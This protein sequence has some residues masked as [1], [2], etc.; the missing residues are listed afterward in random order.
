MTSTNILR[1]LANFYNSLPD[2]IGGLTKTTALPTNNWDMMP[3]SSSTST[4][5]AT[6]NS[7]KG[8]WTTGTYNPGSDTN[9]QFVFTGDNTAPIMNSRIGLLSYT[10]WQGGLV[11]YN[12]YTNTGP[13]APADNGAGR[14]YC[15]ARFGRN[16]TGSIG[17]APAGSYGLFLDSSTANSQIV[18]ST[19]NPRPR[20]PWLRSADS[21]SG[22]YVW[23]VYGYGES[24]SVNSNSAYLYYGVSPALWFNLNISTT[25]GGEG[26]YANPYCLLG[27]ETP[28]LPALTIDT[29]NGSEASGIAL[30]GTAKA[31][32]N[33]QNMTVWAD[34]CNSAGQCV[35]KTSSSFTSTTSGTA[36]SWSLTWLPS[37]L[38]AGTYSGTVWV[39]L[40][41]S[42]DSAIIDALSAQSEPVNFTINPNLKVFPLTALTSRPFSLNVGAV[43]NYDLASLS[44]PATD[45][46]VTAT[47]TAGTLTLSSASGLASPT[48]A[49]F[50]NTSFAFALQ[51]LAS[52]IIELSFE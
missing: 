43:T 12:S 21:S 2:T 24:I 13:T 14:S 30:T 51:D 38:P 15:E 40:A 17:D 19:T 32:E 29:T 5:T 8:S 11:G 20:Y 36:Q 26:S 39:G 41:T 27:S 18:A 52:G 33:G 34:V 28:C 50:G 46:G 42:V 3:I 48:T 25:G 1:T 23:D 22:N 37:E 47:N 6:W 44:L 9:S 16:C 35:R 45:H 49:T 7:T 4:P 31:S 10:E